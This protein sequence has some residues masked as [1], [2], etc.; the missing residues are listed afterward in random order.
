MRKSRGI[1]RKNDILFTAEAPLG[2]VALADIEPYSAGQRLI[3]L[4]QYTVKEYLLNKLMMFFMMSPFFQEQ[5]KEQSTGTTVKG[6][7]AEKLKRF[8]IPVP[9][10]SE[11]TRILEEFEAILPMVKSL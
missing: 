4:Q 8:L 2:Y 6:I 9:P 10:I 7:K 5:L 3:T 1:S 11:Q